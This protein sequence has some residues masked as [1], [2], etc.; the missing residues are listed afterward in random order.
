[1]L[2]D[3]AI[4][5]PL[6]DPKTHISIRSCSADANP[7][8]NGSPNHSK[9]DVSCVPAKNEVQVEASLQITWA[10]GPKQG[11]AVEVAAAAQQMLTH[12]ARQESSCNSTVLFASS[13]E[14]VIGLCTGSQLREQGVAASVLQEFIER[15]QSDGISDTLLVQ[16]CGPDGRGTDFGLGIIANVNASL[17]LIQNAVKT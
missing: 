10:D 16:L 2:L 14:A 3:F 11:N 6:E 1:M 13:G 4:Y 12:L 5:N 8:A 9:R 17:P 15:V 7:V